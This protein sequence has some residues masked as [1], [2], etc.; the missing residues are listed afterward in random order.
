M[1]Y[2]CGKMT[3]SNTDY[4]KKRYACDEA[5]RQRRAEATRRYMKRVMADEERAAAFRARKRANDAWRRARLK[6]EAEGGGE[7]G[8]EGLCDEMMQNL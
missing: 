4:C 7:E 3:F 1:W 6:M 8:T 5:F 2:V